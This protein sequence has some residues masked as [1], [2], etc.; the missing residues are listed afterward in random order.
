ML[1][2][3]LPYVAAVA[4]FFIVSA[5]YFA[6]QFS[7]QSLPQHDVQ[8]YEGMWHDIKTC[9]EQTGED[10]Q[11]TGSMFGGMPAFLINV[12][13]PSQ[14]V[15]NTVG[16]I[17]KVID[18]PAA[19]VFF[20][21][22][23]FWAMMLMMGFAWHTGVVTAFAYGLSTYFM[24]IIGAGHITKMWAAVYAPLMMGA[25]YC[26]MR[27]NV[28]V[29]GALT[30]LFASL[31]IGANHPQITYYFLLAAA[32]FWVSEAV[33]AYREKAL[34]NL[35]RRTCVLLAAGIMAAGSNFAP[36]WYTYTHSKDTIRGGSELAA[37]EPRG[38]D[39]DYAT[40]WSYGITE[41]LNMLVPDFAG[42]S[43][44]DTFGRES[45]TARAFNRMGLRG[46]GDAL[47][48]YWGG[49][50]Y[51]AGPT[52]LGA[53]AIFL[54]LLG[55]FVAQGRDR[56]WLLA[57]TLLAVM[58]SW[59]SN[60]AWFTRLCFAVLPGYNK[61]R[62]VSMAL[63]VAQWS[64]P[65][66][67][68]YALMRIA[69]AKAD[70]RR[71]LKSTA[72]AAGIAGGIC[73]LL[74]VAG[75]KMFDFGRETTADMLS[76]Q[77]L[78]MFKSAGMDDYIRSGAPEAMALDAADAMAAD[79]AGIMR[80]DALRSLLFIVLAAAAVAVVV[81][82][83]L[84]RITVP[85]ILG[86]LLIADMIRVDMRYLSHDDFVPAARNTMPLTEASKQILRDTDPSYR[87]FNLSLS[88][89]N[90]ATTSYYHRSVG[91][92]H[93]AK[94]ARYQDIIER[95]LDPA[96]VVPDEGILDMLNT[97]YTIRGDGSVEYRPTA[98]GAA[99]F[100]RE[101]VP[102]ADAEEEITLTGV[103]D[104]S[105]TAVAAEKDYVA[106]ETFGSGSITLTEYRPNRLVYEYTAD[107]DATAVFSEIYYDKG[108]KAYIDGEEAPYFRADY[109]LRAMRLPAGK[110]VV[111]WRFRAPAWTATQTVTWIF[112]LAILLSVAAAVIYGITIYGGR[113]KTEA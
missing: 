59:G 53:V 87:V 79:R 112:S 50:P 75:G 111:E 81:W 58:L 1:V 61:F 65:L 15:K 78:Y 64:V 54:A 93:G 73:L 48:T 2:R 69:D 80:A 26:T 17:V 70:S 20:A 55:V 31:E 36:L 104:H 108:W 63:V 19:F 95:Y 82:R 8:Q 92:Y 33:R 28:W 39:F 49:Q 76:E 103:V 32:C 94:L 105:Q 46:A 18:T 22:I 77:F 89:F 86:V 109:I 35:A 102:A 51:T 30:A 25:I 97:R 16:Q 100:V 88:P 113:K 14:A 107:A 90:D 57:A 13:Y 85:A 37:A 40:A 21:M 9:R 72:A 11:W 34:K 5:L 29:G 99:W 106:G 23:A 24:L 60:M 42:G 74:L 98:A 68:G 47:P 101:V 84:P 10:P 6:P 27:R 62:T 66:L 3:S 43:S 44:A 71:L 56:W 67:A 12:K 52:Y 45:Q 110:H 38:L 4:A 7:G 96:R 41:S 83:R 91:G